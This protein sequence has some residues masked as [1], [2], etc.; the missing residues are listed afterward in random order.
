LIGT[1]F[2]R[3][4]EVVYSTTNG[5]LHHWW[6]KGGGGPWSDGGT[7]GANCH[8]EIGFVQGD[9]GAPGNF[10]VVAGVDGGR[11]QHFWRDGQGW[12]AGPTFGRNLRQGGATLVQG[13]YG[14]NPNAKPMGH[15]NLEYV[16]VTNNGQLQHFWRTENDFAWH[17]GVIFGGGVTG[18]PVMI[19]G[20]FGMAD[21]AGTGNFELCV[22]VGGRVEHWWRNNGGRGEWIRSAIFG[23]D[24]ASV[25]G[26]CEGSWGMNLEL[27]VQRADGKVQHY[28]RAGSVWNEGPV[29]GPA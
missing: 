21:E 13:S 4:I 6:R 23:H 11:L 28:H 20:Q 9:Y 19:Q 1:T 27:I 12:H 10:E 16:G 15:G 24:I 7:F 18:S 25:V 3:N 29:I 2:N 26:L 8:G 22:A 5:Q 14:D 17:E